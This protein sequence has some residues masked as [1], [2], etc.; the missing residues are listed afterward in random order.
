MMATW[1]QGTGE[2]CIRVSRDG[3]D[4]GGRILQFLG[5]TTVEVGASRAV[6]QTR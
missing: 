3:F 6:A 5:G 4:R 2:E 1:F